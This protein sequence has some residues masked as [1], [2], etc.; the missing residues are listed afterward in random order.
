MNPA[1]HLVLTLGLSVLII[2][3]AV[4]WLSSIPASTW[5]S[6]QPATCLATGGCFCE[7]D[8]IAEAVRQPANAWSSFAYVVVG[9]WILVG[10]AVVTAGGPYQPLIVAAVGVSAVIIG[11]GSAFY[12]ASLTFTGQFFDILGMYLLTG[13]MLVY[14]LQRLLGWSLARAVAVYVVFSVALSIVQVVWPDTRRYLFALV[15]LAALGVELVYRDRTTST[16]KTHWFHLG[17]GLFALAFGVWILDTTG[18]LCAPTSLLQGHALWHLLGA[19]AIGCL[20]MYYRS[21]T[22]HD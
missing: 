19:V 6:W 21:E 9:S 22:Q 4:V 5:T 10:A 2:M 14:A 15:L 8:Q 17:L 11:V 20:H 1:R 13:L 12:H 3:I 18:A 16:L 7:A